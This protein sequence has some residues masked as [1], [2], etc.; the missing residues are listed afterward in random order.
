M[1]S[2]TVGR[3][4]SRL[5]C[6]VCLH[7]KVYESRF[8]SIFFTN[9]VHSST[10]GVDRLQDFDSMTILSNIIIFILLIHFALIF[11][12]EQGDLCPIIR[13]ILCVKDVL[14]EISSATEEINGIGQQIKQSIVS[15]DFYYH[16]N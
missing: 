15:I 12:Q 3:Q 7:L 1:F 6:T 16:R 5:S 13:T 2:M 14:L 8:F 11:S 9:P 4:K 10:Y